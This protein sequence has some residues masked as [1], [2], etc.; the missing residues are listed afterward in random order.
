M[1]MRNVSAHEMGRGRCIPFRN[2]R[3]ERQYELEDVSLC[4]TQWVNPIDLFFHCSLVAGDV[5]G[6]IKQL[7]S[8]VQGILKKN[9]PFEVHP[10]IRYFTTWT[11]WYFNAYLICR[12]KSLMH[13]KALFFFSVQMLLCV[14]SFFSSSAECQQQWSD[15]LTGKETGEVCN[16]RACIF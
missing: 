12:T 6:N 14:G 13:S 1:R 2:T 7:F 15:Y 3:L 4:A 8:K 11:L 16:L 9:G 5:E 10:A